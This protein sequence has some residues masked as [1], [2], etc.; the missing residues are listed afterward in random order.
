MCS[1]SCHSGWMELESLPGLCNLWELFNP[2]L[3]GGVYA[4]HQQTQGDPFPNSGCFLCIDP[5]SSIVFSANY[6]HFHLSELYY[7]S[8]LSETTV[9]C[10]VPFPHAGSWK[11]PNII[12]Q[13]K[14]W[15]LH[16]LF[17]FSPG[18]YCLVPNEWSQLFYTFLST[19]LGEKK[20]IIPG[21]K[22]QY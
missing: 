2:L 11:I 8:H 7:L 15:S 1:I 6:S 5:S 4:A 9:F 12:M 14:F 10:W 17:L 13:G 22:I 20:L 21:R 16:H 18:L 3:L 19:F